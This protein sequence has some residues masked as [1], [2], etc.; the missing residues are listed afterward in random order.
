[1][2]P[3]FTLGL[4]AALASG[5]AF[6][7]Y[8]IT[9]KRAHGAAAKPLHALAI[10]S[11]LGLLFPLWGVAFLSTQAHGVLAFNLTL[12][13]LRWPMGWAACTILTTTGLVWLLRTFSLSEVAG[14]KK[15][16][17]TLG[18]AATDVL[19]FGTHFP[20][21]TLL[22]IG[23]LLGGALGLSG[24]RN[25]LPTRTEWLIIGLWCAVLV[26]QISLYKY[27][28][29]QQLLGGGS[30]MAH[31]VLA[32]M[33]ATGG[34]AALWLLPTIRAQPLPRPALILSLWACVLA[35]TVLEGF[36]YA[37]LPL[38]LVLVVTMLPAALMAAHDLWRGDLPRSPKVWASLGV[39]VAGFLVLIVGK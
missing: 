9:I 23:L 29:Q 27:G 24:A 2:S 4:F 5:V 17:I 26:L 39:L 13:A 38:A 16:L 6:A 8:Q 7:L 32:Q 1:M 35:G 25:R 19:V 20:T 21:L 10:P 37:G 36:A 31:T 12:E 15:A 11:W 14:Y 28:Q 30:I 22:A 34:Y 3:S 18:A 33:F